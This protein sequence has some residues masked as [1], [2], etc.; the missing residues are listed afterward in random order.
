MKFN[1]DNIKTFRFISAVY[2]EKI[3]QAHLNYALD[4]EHYFTETLT[5]PNA[6]PLTTDSRLALN[7]VLKQLHLV[8][9]ISYY[10]TSLPPEISI[11]TGHITRENAKFLDNLYLQGLGEFAY[12]NQH[13]LQGKINFP[14]HDDVTQMTNYRLPAKTIVPVGGGKDSVVSIELLRKNNQ[15]VTLFSVGQ[16]EI[17]KQVVAVSGLPYIQVKRQLSK[18]LF[19]LNQ[20][21]AYN[22]HVPISAILAY[23]MAVSA[24]LYGFDTVVMSNE[25]SANIG[26]LSWQQQE[27]N[28]QYSKSLAFEQVVQQQFQTILPHFR[29]FSLLRPLSE[30]HI[31][32]LF[33][34][35]STYHP[36]FSS[37]NHNFRIQRD[38]NHSGLWCLDC[39]KCRFVFLALAP[40]IAQSELLQ[41]FGTNLLED[42]QQQAGFSA[43][44]GIDQ[45]KPFECVGEIE[46]CQVALFLLTQKE[47]WQTLPMIQYYQQQL[48]FDAG[49]IL[50]KMRKVFTPSNQHQIPREYQYLFD[51]II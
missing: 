3:Q 44:L 41:I 46:E 4:R 29:Y 26:N 42:K 18:Q 28:H 35:F 5:F 16:S 19:T 32:R 34:Q 21:G 22:G 40:F 9:G 31:A 33:S 43:L 10:K 23:I 47:D 36:V 13:N 11:E 48:N 15:D 27:I 49:D 30:L 51:E 14:Y 50:D 6:L 24:I 12:C 1:P 45:H 39:P 20:Q 17:I 37:C 38:K 2:N 7:T 25:R 8:A